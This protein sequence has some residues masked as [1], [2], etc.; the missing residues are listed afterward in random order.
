[1]HGLAAGSVVLQVSYSP[2]RGF[3]PAAVALSLN[4]Y[5]YGCT[6]QLVS[7]A[8]PLLYAAEMS[9]DPRVKRSTDA[10]NDAVGRL[11]DRESMDGSFGL[12]RVGDQ[13]ADAWLG[14]YATD[15]IVEAKL[16]GSPIP[17]SA[18]ESAL[19]AMRR[20]SRPDGFVSVGYRMDYPET[21]GPVRRTILGQGDDADA[22]TS[23]GLRPLCPGQ[24]RTRR[25]GPVAL[26]ARRADEV[27]ELADRRGPGWR[28]SGDDGRSG[29][30]A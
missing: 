4:R 3:D 28:R 26:V 21:G 17:D 14:A 7:T 27:A 23:L 6:E 29:A 13:E 2:F 20:I 11:L 1:M 16:Q 10:L 12:W 25:S 30:G 9:S 22:L 8:Y 15:F 24:G 5:P 19:D 18:Y